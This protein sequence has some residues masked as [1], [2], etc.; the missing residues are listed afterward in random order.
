MFDSRHALVPD[1]QN[2][3]AW[4]RRLV[5][6]QQHVLK[7]NGSQGGGITCALRHLS[8]AK[9]RFDSATGPARKFCC[10][11]AAITIL[12]A[13][14]AADYRLQP[15]QR[16]RAQELLDA[17]TPGR[18]VAAGLFADY[19]AE[20]SQFFRQYEKTRHDIAKSYS[21]KKR[22]MKRLETL[23]KDGFVLADLSDDIAAGAAC[24]AD[25]TCTKIAVSQAMAFGTL[26]Y[27]DRTI[28]LWPTGAREEAEASLA[29]MAD[30]TDA[31][32]SRVEAEMPDRGIVCAFAAFDLRIWKRI[33]HARLDPRKR[34]KVEVAVRVQRDRAN[35]LACALPSVASV[36]VTAQSLCTV[37]EQLCVACPEA[38][39]DVDD[40]D[41]DNNEAI[42]DNRRHWG[43]ALARGQCP[44]ELP[45]LVYWYISILDNTGVV[46]RMNVATRHISANDADYYFVV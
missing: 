27:K 33:R 25:E 9:Q 46:R 11:L 7:V 45:Q 12:L 36:A 18:I 43:S 13:T 39:P 14:V 31:A 44:G 16:L 5:L 34:T 26:K 24:P 41:E 28:T 37:A 3:E 23:F 32:L 21:Q 1:I 15:A 22:F 4:Q 35:R 17:M 38:T 20:C 29:A 42:T 40:S 19:M 6:A 8:F 2:S 30:I 10:L